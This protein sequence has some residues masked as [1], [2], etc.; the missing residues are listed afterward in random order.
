MIFV[1]P[2]NSQDILLERYCRKVYDSDVVPT[3]QEKDSAVVIRCRDCKYF[4]RGNDN[5]LSVCRYKSDLY[6]WRA[7]EEDDYCSHAIKRGE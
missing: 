5:K 3:T 4:Y 2:N 1:A 7:V 6:G